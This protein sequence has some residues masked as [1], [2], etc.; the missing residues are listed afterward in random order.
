MQRGFG[1]ALK[2][3]DLANEAAVS[4]KTL[5][6]SALRSAN[7][8]NDQLEASFNLSRAHQAV[9][10]TNQRGYVL[11]SPMLRYAEKKRFPGPTGNWGTNG[12]NR[13]GLD[14][15]INADSLFPNVGR[16]ILFQPIPCSV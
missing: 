7:P 11:V 14:T 5:D 4:Y 12:R 13:L 3:D 6:V 10:G 16:R 1:Q 2:K 8:N 9:K 15:V